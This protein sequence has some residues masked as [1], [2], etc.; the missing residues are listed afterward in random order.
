MIIL[1]LKGRYS[2]EKGPTI[3][4]NL[5]L[6]LLRD[7][8]R[9]GVLTLYVFGDSEL[10]IRWMR[11]ENQVQRSSLFNLATKLRDISSTFN[12][13]SFDHIYASN[14]MVMHILFQKQRLFGPLFHVSKDEFR[15]GT[16]VSSKSFVF[17]ST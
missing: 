8:N 4:V 15:S 11:G 3:W 16:V 7:T 12:L 9:K 6:L 14:S 2:L 13:I 10:S 1:I 17:Q 5:L